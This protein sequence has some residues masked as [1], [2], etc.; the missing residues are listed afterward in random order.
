SLCSSGDHPDLHSF[1]T[2]RSSDLTIG[3]TS[4]CHLVTWSSS[5]SSVATRRRATG[6]PTGVI[7]WFS[8]TT[9]RN[10]I[11]SDVVGT[12]GALLDGFRSEEHTSELQSRRDLVCRLL[13]E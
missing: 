12:V 7:G 10:W 4:P 2:R 1:P 13:L 3:C 11:A 5:S 8:I 6:G 9:S